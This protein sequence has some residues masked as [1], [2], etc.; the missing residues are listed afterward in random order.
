MPSIR[1]AVPLLALVAAAVVGLGA[2]LFNGARPLSGS[3]ECRAAGAASA[4]L[5][6]LAKG[7]VAALAV[8][9]APKP[10][11]AITFNGP[12]GRPTELA[13]LNGKVRLLNIWATW[14]VPCRQEMPALDRLQ[15]EF[16]GPEFEVVAVNVDTRNLERPRTWLQENG[17]TRLAYYADPSGKVMQVLQRSGELV[18]LP[19]SILVDRDGCEIAVL[20]G[21]AEW[22]SA[23]AKA[24]IAAAL[25]RRRPAGS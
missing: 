18:G 2:A 9:S 1:R 22:A 15:G 13:A 19:T 16:G 17:V 8:L 10:A 12:D 11:P 6:P 3:G 23:D 25:A 5:A 7:E 20:K 24:L 21:P 14:C 4:R